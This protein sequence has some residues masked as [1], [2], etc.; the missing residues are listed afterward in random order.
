M[1]KRKFKD[2]VLGKVLISQP[3]KNLL[4][5]IPIIGP[6]AGNILDESKGVGFN[7]ITSEP[8]EI[9]KENIVLNIIQSVVV[10]VL[11]Y[12]AITGKISFEEAEK[13][14]DFFTN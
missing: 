9:D 2:S 4:K 6:V 13:A 14:K 5:I 7:E 1:S 8:G 12:L 10:A 3:I 11:L